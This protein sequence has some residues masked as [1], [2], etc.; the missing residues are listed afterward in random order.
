MAVGNEAGHRFQLTRIDSEGQIGEAPEQGGQCFDGFEAGQGCAEAVVRPVAEG[1]VFGV[2]AGGVE[3]VRIV[4]AWV[5][6]GGGE[7]GDDRL[8]G[9]DPL[10]CDVDIGDRV[11]QRQ[12]RHRRRE[13]QRFLDQLR[14]P[15]GADPQLPQQFGPGQHLVNGLV[16]EVDGGLVAGSDHQQQGV[17]EFVLAETIIGVAVADEQAGH[18]LPRLGATARYQR[19]QEADQFGEGSLR[20]TLRSGGEDLVDTHPQPWLEV[21]GHAHQGGDHP[22]RH[23]CGVVLAQVDHRPVGPGGEIVEQPADDH[24]DLRAQGGDTAGGERRA[25]EFAQTLMVFAIGGEHVAHRHPRDQRPVRGHLTGAEC[26]PMLV[27]V[28]GYPPI[29]EQVLAHIGVGDRPRV[30]I[31]GQHRPDQRPSVTQG[32][33][34]AGDVGAGDIQYDRSSSGR[35]GRGGLHIGHEGIS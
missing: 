34:L 25:D 29:G 18:V 8:T 9:L 32:D 30:D 27:G 20:V 3:G 24:P 35:R 7:R 12:V 28:L 15:D 19:G 17:D 33:G 5:A 11:A 14:P 13:P 10:A 21:G 26:G 31:A 16:D 4:V 6:V 23:L 1:Q 2:R 22:Q